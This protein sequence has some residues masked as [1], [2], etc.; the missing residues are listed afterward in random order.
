MAQWQAWTGLLICALLVLLALTRRDARRAA[1]WPLL[2]GGL[3]G[4][5]YAHHPGWS[6]GRVIDGLAHGAWRR[7]DWLAGLSALCLFAGAIISSWLSGRWKMQR[8][9]PLRGAR[10]LGGGV[11]LG[12]G[13][14]FVP[15]G[16]D[17]LLLWSIPGLALYGV[18]AYGTMLLTLTALLTPA[19]LWRQLRSVAR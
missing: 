7:M 15:G 19:T 10:C 11:L 1:L 5:V 16:N 14:A 9:N 12:L 3:A 18:L 13:A 4:L 6:Y 8:P 17:S 2:A